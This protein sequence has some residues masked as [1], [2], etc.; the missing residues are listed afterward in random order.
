[1][2]KHD[3]EPFVAV[4]KGDE[5]WKYT[6]PVGFE[7]GGAGG[8]TDSVKD[9]VKD[10]GTPDN[11]DFFAN[12]DCI[13]IVFSD[14]VFYSGLSDKI[15]A[16]AGIKIESLHNV[17]DDKDHWSKGLYGTIEAESQNPVPRPFA[18]LNTATARQGAVIHI[19]KSPPKPIAILYKNTGA[20]ANPM[21][22]HLIKLD[23]GVTL[24]LLESGSAGNRANI[25][26]ELDIADNATLHH[27]RADGI[28]QTNATLTSGF[29]RLGANSQYR[30]FHFG[31]NTRMVR[32]EMVVIMTGEGA[33][34]T[35]AAAY[36]GNG[37]AHNDDTVLV[38]HKAPHCQS[39]QVFK[40][41][42]RNGAV[43]V[44]QGKIL[45][46]Q[47]AQKTDGYQIGQALML[48]GDSVFLV[49]PELEIY[50]DDVIC[51]HGSTVGAIEEDA[52]FYLVSRGIRRAEAQD[53]LAFAFLA[54][55]VEEV[56]DADIAE[57]VRAALV[58][59][60]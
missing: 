57:A 32:N 10:S 37:G 60:C 25:V 19:S 36:I 2:V 21:L 5:Y 18:R 42:L 50:A 39:R 33:Q 55:A 45:V 47:P 23:D 13:R 29:A 9:S 35:L 24:T 26:T 40:K 27:I 22:H 43:G 11:T 7:A 34:V 8:A 52:L 17:L 49:K 38:I 3:I 59:S 48:D 44:F 41:V 53:I 15:L 51:S 46:E 6:S 20:T 12:F 4:K 16:Q 58:V 31:K 30:A 56:A 54:E 1:M 28:N 14:G